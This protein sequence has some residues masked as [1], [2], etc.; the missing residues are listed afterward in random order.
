M[1]TVH[2][3]HNVQVPSSLMA[4]LP[5]HGGSDAFSDLWSQ[6]HCLMSPA[7]AGQDTALVQS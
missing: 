3:E 4:E 6:A 7:D 5:P 2:I 1:A